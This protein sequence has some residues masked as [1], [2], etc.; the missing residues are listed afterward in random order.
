MVTASSRKTTRINS[1]AKERMAETTMYVVRTYGKADCYGLGEAVAD[2][3]VLFRAGNYDLTRDE[4]D[5]RIT[6]KRLTL[7]T[8]V[9]DN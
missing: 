2:G 5:R 8:S 1:V 7:T 4:L 9:G 6:A 3:C